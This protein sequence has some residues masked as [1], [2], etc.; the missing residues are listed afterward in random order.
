[1]IQYLNYFFC[2]II[3]FSSGTLYFHVAEPPSPPIQERLAQG[4]HKNPKN[5]RSSGHESTH[6]NTRRKQYRLIQLAR[7]CLNR[8]VRNVKTLFFVQMRLYLL[9]LFGFVIRRRRERSHN[10]GLVITK[11][12]QFRLKRT[13]GRLASPL[14]T[15]SR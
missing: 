12:P 11:S 8:T 3:Q 4:N 6:S 14:V 15:S 9:I 1:M 2:S 10:V 7:L 13:I 5:S